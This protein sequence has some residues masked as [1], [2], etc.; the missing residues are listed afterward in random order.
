MFVSIIQIIT[1]VVSKKVNFH[2][3]TLKSV[4]KEIFHE[5][6]FI[7]MISKKVTREYGATTIEKNIYLFDI[8]LCNQNFSPAIFYVV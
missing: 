4:K 8:I 1:K 2:F 5:L 7:Q 3:E 6:Q